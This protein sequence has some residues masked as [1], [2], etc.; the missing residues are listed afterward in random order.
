MFGRFQSHVT[1]SYT[2]GLK[3]GFR[4]VTWGDLERLSCIDAEMCEPMGPAAG[5][6]ACRG[7]D[8]RTASRGTWRD[9]AGA[10]QSACV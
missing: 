4:R 7:N 5:S 3:I 2:R 8:V 6:I 9:S 10:T 1:Y